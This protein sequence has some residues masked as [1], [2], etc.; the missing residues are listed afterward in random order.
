MIVFPRSRC[1]S[2]VLLCDYCARHRLYITN[3]MFRHK[4]VHMCIWHQDTLGPCEICS[5][6]SWTWVKR[7]AKVSTDHHLV[8]DWLYG[9]RCRSDLLD[10]KLLRVSAGRRSFNSHLQHSFNHVPKESGGHLVWMDFVFLLSRWLTGC[11]HKAVVH[12]V[13]GTPKPFDGHW[14]GMPSSW[15]SDK[16]PTGTFWPVGLRRQLISKACSN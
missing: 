16:S 9:V 15:R 4:G 10:P 12:V 1:S 8:V 6:M 7:E 11:V 5:H 13:L 2:V 14:H 3:T